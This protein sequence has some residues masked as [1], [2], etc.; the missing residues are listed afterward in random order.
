MPEENARPTNQQPT[1]STNSGKSTKS[2]KSQKS[3]K[4]GL[5]QKYDLDKTRG[6]HDVQKAREKY[7][8]NI[9][10]VNDTALA[11]AADKVRSR[12]VRFSSNN[13]NDMVE[14]LV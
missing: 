13:D 4:L 9:E 11:P 14:V 3:Q 10:S 1:T 12:G 7:R 5:S 8:S 2:E 6:K